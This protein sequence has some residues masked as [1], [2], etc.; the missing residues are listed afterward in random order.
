MQ[1]P[2]Y[3][4]IMAGGVGTRFWP[5]SRASLPKQFL[6]ILGI[7]SSLLQMTFERFHAWIPTENIFVLTHKDYKELVSEQLPALSENNIICEPDR[8]NTAPCIAYAAF[9]ISKMNPDATMVVVPS[10]HLILKDTVFEA[11]VQKAVIFAN[12]HDALLTLGIKPTRPD[13]GYGYIE[14][15]NEGIDEIKEVISFTEKPEIQKAEIFLAA[16]NYAWNAGIFIWSSAAIL[17]AFM[18]HSPE[19]YKV[20]ERGMPHYNTQSEGSFIENH[21]TGA[22]STSV[23]YAILEKASNVFTIPCDIGWSDL[24]TWNSLYEESAHDAAKN[25]CNTSLLIIQDATGNMIRT[26]HDKL[27]VI[28]GLKDFIV[29]D[30]KDVLLIWPKEKEQEIKELTGMVNEKFN[31]KFN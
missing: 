21:F 13:T 4:L 8:R 23:D 2:P 11:T 28:E 27:V 3:I 19:I 14:F 15:K 25:V 12:E 18:H 16:G 26:S 7:G 29:I 30:E 20:F 6:D 10:D 1:K 17:K 9:K 22:T 5:S 31:G 24:G